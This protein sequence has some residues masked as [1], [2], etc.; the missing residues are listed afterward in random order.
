METQEHVDDLL[1]TLTIEARDRGTPVSLS[2]EVLVTIEILSVNE[3]AP[4]LQH[5]DHLYVKISED[6]AHGS[7]ICDINATDQDFGQDGLLTYSIISGNDGN[8][9]AINSNTG[10]I[11]VNRELDY[12]TIFRYS[13]GIR[14]SDSAPQAQRFSIDAKVTVR[15]TNVNDSGGVDVIIQEMPSRITPPGD[16]AKEV[17]VSTSTPISVV[18]LYENG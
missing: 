13:L 6:L 2:N 3:F 8:H 18:L 4:K 12:E 15:L 16:P 10:V 11:S 7:K 5:S 14:V 9:F 17:G 1:Y